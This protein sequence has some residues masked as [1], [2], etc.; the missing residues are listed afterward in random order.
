LVG[1]GLTYTPAERLAGYLCS[2]VLGTWE[3]TP[4]PPL[5]YVLFP[6]LAP[7]GPL[8]LTRLSGAEATIQLL[9]YSHNLRQ[10]PRFG[11]DLMPR[12]LAQVECFT[13]HWNEDLAAAA[14]LVL[15][16]V[17]GVR[18]RARPR[19]ERGRLSPRLAEE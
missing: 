14:D 6:D 3:R 1:L 2:T 15:G 7:D 5:R 4:G 10:Q 13:L 9:R 17:L 8:A 11:L 19:L 12:L 18:A 16:L